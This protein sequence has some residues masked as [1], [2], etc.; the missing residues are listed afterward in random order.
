MRIFEKTALVASSC[1]LF[2]L[3]RLVESK[4]LLRHRRKLPSSLPELPCEEGLNVNQSACT[5]SD[6]CSGKCRI[7][8]VTTGCDNMGNFIG[9]Y[10]AIC[11]RVSTSTP[12]PED[13]NSNGGST[14]TS[15]PTSSPNSVSRAPV[16]GSTRAPVP[17]PTSAPIPDPTPAPV[18]APTPAPV[19]DLTPAPVPAPTPAPVN[20]TAAPV[21]PTAAPVDPTVAPAPPPTRDNAQLSCIQSGSTEYNIAMTH[22]NTNCEKN[23]DC[24]ESG[25]C[26]IFTFITKGNSMYLACDSYNV[27]NGWPDICEDIGRDN[28][29]C[30]DEISTDMTT[31][32]NTKCTSN[33]ACNGDHKCRLIA[34]VWLDCDHGSHFNMWPALCDDVPIRTSTA[35]AEGGSIG[36]SAKSSSSDSSSSESS[37]SSDS[38]SSNSS[39][40]DSSSSD[41]SSSDS[42]SSDSSSSDSSSSS[43]DSSPSSSLNDSNTIGRQDDSEDDACENSGTTDDCVNIE[44]PACSAARKNKS[45]KCESSIECNRG[46]CR[47]H[48]GRN[49][50]GERVG[51]GF[52]ACDEGHFF[53]FYPEVCT[54]A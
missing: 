27:F 19:P 9:F 21:D 37:S 15:N 34:G 52:F 35:T 7:F 54:I 20:P 45:S 12:P 16:P 38:S 1:S 44:S 22:S 25:K 30:V 36:T 41:S 2:L 5:T 18:P 8:G 29:N 39:S 50:R 13:N 6:Q 42:S 48:S 23:S 31:H 46:K 43:N 4:P 49:S 32:K 3:L 33:D 11:E 40:S 24:G 14:T 26:R 53:K 47:L 51:S 28:N 17:A 10:P